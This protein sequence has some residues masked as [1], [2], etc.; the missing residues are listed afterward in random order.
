MADSKKPAR[1]ST[2]RKPGPARKPRAGQGKR[3]DNEW[4]STGPKR[5]GGP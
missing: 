5:T 2:P 4:S 3:E 1:P